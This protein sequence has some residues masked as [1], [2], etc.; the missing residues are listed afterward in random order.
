MIALLLGLLQIE[1]TPAD[2][3]AV[4]SGTRKIE[5]G[6]TIWFPEG[7]YT[8]PK[9][10]DV[11]LAG[12]A[13]ARIV[14]R[15]RGRAT[16]LDT[17]LRIVAPS[18]H[19]TIRDLEIAG[20]VPAE[21]RVT[22][23]KGPHPKGLPGGDGVNVYAGADVRLINCVIRDTCGN[24]VG[25]WAEASGGEIH[26][27]LIFGN[28]WKGPDRGHGHCIYT[29]NKDGTKTVSGNI[30]VAGFDGAYTLHAYGS[31]KAFVDHYVVEENIAFERGPFLVGGGRPSVDIAVRRNCL[32]G[33]GLQLGYSAPHNEDCEVRDN[34]APRGLSIHRFKKVVDEGNVR[35]L[36]PALFRL[37]RN[38]HDPLRA[39]LAVYN[40]AKAAE[41]KVDVGG[42]LSPGE[43]FRL[44]DPRDFHGKPVLEGTCTGTSVLVPMK[45]DFGAFVLLKSEKKP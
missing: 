14:V 30:L 8:A 32:H 20:S 31:S 45:A 19:L 25:W 36:P 1:V 18:A 13:E 43:A 3:A 16:L 10:V 5:P 24:G 40:G 29:Q 6:T 2:F 7:V 9:G 38:R 17:P 26:G 22:D 15:G 33:V 41:V 35:A 23:L 39:H 12:T 21:R 34:V 28:G 37:F 11:R 42:F 44:L 27:C 4:L